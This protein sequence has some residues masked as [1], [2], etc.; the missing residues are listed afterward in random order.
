[1]K[2]QTKAIVAS[3]V[4][5][6]LALA[7]VSGV[8]YSWFSDTESSDINVSSAK[9]D[10]DGSYTDAKISKTSDPLYSGEMTTSLDGFTQGVKNL[11]IKDLVA[12]RTI[13]ATYVL[14]N[15]STV[16]TK[17]RMYVCVD[18]ITDALA[19]KSISIKTTT[20][21]SSLAVSPLTF[22]N[23][24][25]YAIGGA[26]SGFELN[27]NS[28]ESGDK[29]T[30]KITIKFDSSIAPID[31]FSVKIVNEAYQSD[32]E[33]SEAQVI[34]NGSATMPTSPVASDITFK[35]TA[36]AASASATPADVE[37]NF[38][39]NAANIATNNGT[40]SVSLT[41]QMLDPEGSVAKIELSLVGPGAEKNFG[42]DWV[43]VTIT[44]PNV[45]TDLK[46]YYDGSESEQPEILSITND[47][48]NTKITFRTNHFSEFEI[49]ENEMSVYDEAGLDKALLAGITNIDV[50][51]KITL[52]DRGTLNLKGAT[53][54]TMIKEPT[55]AILYDIEI[56]NG[57]IINKEGDRVINVDGNGEY[58]G[59]DVVL[60]NVNV[61][62]PTSG[63]Y[64][65][66]ISFYNT[67][68]S[69]L[70][71]DN[72]TFSCNYYAI[73][74]AG[75]CPDFKLNM[76]NSTISGWCAYQ[77]WSENT[78]ATFT[79]CTLVGTNDKGYDEEGWNNFA[80]IVFNTGSNSTKLTLD[81]C[82]IKAIA[83]PDEKKENGYNT[84]YYMSI[85]SSEAVIY[86]NNC[87]L[88][89]ENEDGENW[90]YE[91]KDEDTKNA[92]K[93]NINVYPQTSDVII[94]ID[95]N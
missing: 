76:T 68:E 27:K 85:R 52:S 78:N 17:Y 31:N 7:A 16:N 90:Y 88:F 80:T 42:S 65:R 89:C 74:V 82:T 72:C 4:V 9:I 3:V 91:L 36:P 83:K 44:I 70:T 47:G 93:N 38:S 43:T 28:T 51:S 61:V 81:N 73:N 30:F 6:A 77:T 92:V 29:Y 57:T 24:I 54:T 87:V 5:I 48:P 2:A 37:V 41:T 1:M 40:T 33:Y 32:F 56:T 34:R 66:G 75:S 22:S 64:T 11:V 35:G 15:L 94:E 14:K 58:N 53:L 55:I 49:L 59:I 23:G 39:K 13:E 19:N 79:D 50:C 18:G 10:I 95:G 46:V 60:R 26:N 84:Q 69:S 62:G 20:T 8:T 25:A 67:S 45:Y 71:A 21:P 86:V 63:T 12:D